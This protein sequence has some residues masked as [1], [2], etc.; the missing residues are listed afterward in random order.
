MV[1]FPA[2]AVMI[3]VLSFNL[4]GNAW[5]D[6]SPTALAPNSKS[7]TSPADLLSAISHFESSLLPVSCAVMTAGENVARA[8]LAT[9]V[10]FTIRDVI[11]CLVDILLSFL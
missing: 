9:L 3:A 8:K 4:L 7:P 10:L 11:N 5:R 6:C 2:I 1:F